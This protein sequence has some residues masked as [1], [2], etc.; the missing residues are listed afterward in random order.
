MIPSVLDA[1]SVSFSATLAPQLSALPHADPLYSLPKVGA[2]EFY[3][4]QLP[5]LTHMNKVHQPTHIVNQITK[6][7]IKTPSR[8]AC[9]SVRENVVKKRKKSC[10]FGFWK[11][12]LKNVHSFTGHLITQPLISLLNYRKSVAYRSPTSNILLRSVD[13]RNHATESC[14]W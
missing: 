2:Y 1:F 6:S 8:R 9:G 5:C 7:H 13:T 3:C 12:T 11:K 14:V 4:R 10:F